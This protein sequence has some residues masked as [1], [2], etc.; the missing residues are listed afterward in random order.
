MTTELT[1]TTVTL[2]EA[3]D[4]VEEA[5]GGQIL[6]VDTALS[7]DGNFET[8]HDDYI[9]ELMLDDG[10]DLTVVVSA[11]YV[12]AVDEDDAIEI[13]RDAAEEY[14]DVTVSPALG[15]THVVDE[16]DDDEDDDA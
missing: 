7:W 13:A 4:L 16:D 8:M 3:Y 11:R 2:D 14:Y 5:E 6:W 15:V 9:I 12:G 10:R 1:V